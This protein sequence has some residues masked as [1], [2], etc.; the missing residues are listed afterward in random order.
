MRSGK[1]RDPEYYSKRVARLNA[2]GRCATHVE[3]L[4]PCARCALWRQAR[5]QRALAKGVCGS[6][7]DRL[8]VSHGRCA[9]CVE[10]QKAA[11]TRSREKLKRLVVDAY[12]GS[13]ACCGETFL[14]FLGI[15]HTDGK[16]AIH[17]RSHG[18]TS[19]VPFYRWLRDNNFPSGFQVLCHNCNVFKRTG[20]E[21]L[22]PYRESRKC[23]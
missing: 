16:G 3:E 7:V 21:C 17:R 22:C 14:G 1:P 11:N 4:L 13:C 12:G 10:R 23:A 9:E 18:L 8:A 6:H 15:D 2:E 20:V 19:G 5:W